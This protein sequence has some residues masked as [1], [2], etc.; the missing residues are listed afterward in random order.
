MS[1]ALTFPEGF[2]IGGSIAANQVEGACREGGRGLSVW[3]CF[4]F[5]G[6]G[7]GGDCFTLPYDDV[8]RAAADTCDTRYPKRRGIDFYHRYEQ[9]IELF[10]Q[11]GFRALRLSINWLRIFPAGD[12]TE[13]NAQGLAF[14]HRVFSC[15]RSRGIE[16]EV[17]MSHFDLPVHL[18]LAYGGWA[19]RELV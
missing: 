6:E 19:N 9:D 14:Y 18:S 5:N 3:D 4:A 13:P 2:L 12:E 7:Q 8:V 1:Q 16:P 11:M 17:T 15:L 10:A